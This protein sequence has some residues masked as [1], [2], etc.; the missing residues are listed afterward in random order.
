[1]NRAFPGAAG[2][3][4]PVRAHCN[5]AR[6][7]A[8]AMTSDTGGAVTRLACGVTPEENPVLP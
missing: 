3:R 2:G 7:A 1:M 4:R 5:G 8:R 6:A